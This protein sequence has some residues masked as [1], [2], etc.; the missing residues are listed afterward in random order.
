[1][2]ILRYYSSFTVI[3]QILFTMKR[4]SLFL[5]LWLLL[6]SLVV[7]GQKPW[8]TSLAH[9]GLKQSA[10]GGIRCMARD[11][12]EGLVPIGENDFVAY[13]TWHGIAS[14]L[15]LKLFDRELEGYPEE[16]NQRGTSQAA[17]SNPNAYLARITPDGEVKWSVSTIDGAVEELRVATEGDRS[18]VVMTVCPT[19]R[20]HR[21]TLD[22]RLF[23]LKS[24]NGTRMTVDHDFD[25]PTN[26]QEFRGLLYVY[27]FEIGPNGELTT[28]WELAKRTAIN[29]KDKQVWFTLRDLLVKQGE[30][31]LS[32]RYGSCS[33]ELGNPPDAIIHTTRTT[34]ESDFEV[35]AVRYQGQKV[36]GSWVV[37]SSSPL[38]GERVNALLLAPDAIYAS[39]ELKRSSAEACLVRLFGYEVELTDVKTVRAILRLDY[40]LAK[41]KWATRLPGSCDAVGMALYDDNL[42]VTGSY[43]AEETWG[44][45]H[46]PDPDAD[47]EGVENAAY[48]GALSTDAGALNTAASMVAGFAEG[49]GIAV[50]GD[51][52]YSMFDYAGQSFGSSPSEAMDIIDF[53]GTKVQVELGAPESNYQIGLA[54]HRIDGG[55]VGFVPVLFAKGYI[56]IPVSGPVVNRSGF[57]LGFANQ[58]GNG[59]GI[60]EGVECAGQPFATPE[61]DGYRGY[62][63]I[64]LFLTL[65]APRY[66]LS[67]SQ[68]G[69]ARNAQVRVLRRG[70]EVSPGEKKL[71]AGDVI[72]IEVAV[73]GHTGA[74]EVS[75]ATPV[76]SSPNA[77]SVVGDVEVKVTYTK[78]PSLWAKV[79]YTW[80]VEP[81]QYNQIYSSYWGDYLRTNI[82]EIPQGDLLRIAR[83]GIPAG[84]VLDVINVSGATPTGATSPPDGATWSPGYLYIV[85]AG[86]KEVVVQTTIKRDEN[87]WKT[88]A[89]PATTT[90]TEGNSYTLEVR[91]KNQALA[92]GDK[93]PVG[94]QFTITFSGKQGMLPTVQ[95]VGAKPVPEKYYGRSH[96]YPFTYTVEDNVVITIPGFQSRQV[97]L[98]IIVPK[99][100]GK[101]LVYRDAIEDD[102]H[103]L[104][105]KKVSVDW[106]SQLVVKAAPDSGYAAYDDKISNPLTLGVHLEGLLLLEGNTYRLLATTSARAS[107][108]F[109]AEIYRLSIL[110]TNGVTVVVTS[111]DGGEVVTPS[112]SLT[113]GDL[114]LVK[115]TND[116]PDDQVLTAIVVDGAKPTGNPDEY[117]VMGNV[118]VRTTVASLVELQ[119]KGTPIGGYTISWHDGSTDQQLEVTSTDQ[120]LK[121]KEGSTITITVKLPEGDYKLVDVQP[122][123]VQPVEGKVGVY[124]LTLVASTTVQ[125]NIVQLSRYALTLKAGEHGTLNVVYTEPG[126]SAVSR[127]LTAAEEALQLLAETEVQ[128][129]ASPAPHF[130]VEQIRVGQNLGFP[131]GGLFTLSQPVAVS[132]I[133]ARIAYRV[134][135]LAIRGGGKIILSHHHLQQALWPNDTVHD[136]DTLTLKLQA[137]EGFELVHNSLRVEGLKATETAGEYTVEGN[138]RVKADFRA[139]GVVNPVADVQPPKLLTNPVAETAVITHA[140]ALRAYSVVGINGTVHLTGRCGGGAECRIPVHSLPSGIYLLRL[141]MDGGQ[142]LILRFNKE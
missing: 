59:V 104:Q 134:K 69:E 83:S 46:L 43:D 112:T 85:D 11:K 19:W 9:M 42:Y 90:D 126:K 26:D 14:C 92:S 80:E 60:T 12:Q 138:V 57:T 71:L 20:K 13:G 114:I 103:L 7:L 64:D 113:F 106:N 82:K 50:V 32:A 105:G 45:V 34:G 56:Q 62:D 131:N 77:Y 35:I 73:L 67:V 51:R 40:Q 65:A 31:T 66:N 99:K 6:L 58:T 75:G 87:L 115:A 22:H 70:V 79:S 18:Y 48:W 130:R 16:A 109:I 95:C 30:V 33:V 36:K 97:D 100:H 120:Q 98:S 84:Y 141:Q 124:T 101:L 5:A 49:Q 107:V 89:F 96:V 3:S 39:V 137:S 38:A 10:V 55:F 119:L 94:E 63:C 37:E 128:V 44:N 136:G 88:I 121:L 110:P 27:A 140:E 52:V 81:G 127:E 102:A 17:A 61:A 116:R 25:I 41:A 123:Y 132:V 8:P 133:F 78:D 108:K 2:E 72:S 117:R 111:K 1:M 54:C 142:T 135:E 28:P 122:V 53:G 29:G 68:Q 76:P 4:R 23:T 21:E 125:V 86:A 129:S 91:Y 118:A 139:T 24:S 74:V 93:I 47:G 15:N